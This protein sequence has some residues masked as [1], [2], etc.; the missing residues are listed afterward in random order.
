MAGNILHVQYASLAVHERV[1]IHA[2]LIDSWSKI[3]WEGHGCL[4]DAYGRR[5]EEVVG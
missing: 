5:I 4:F 3:T 1:I 2:D